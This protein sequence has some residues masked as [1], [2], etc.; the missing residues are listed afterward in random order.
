[1]TPNMREELIRVN[2]DLSHEE[3]ALREA[4]L[5]ASAYATA[6][7]AIANSDLEDEANY[8]HLHGIRA[9]CATLETETRVMRNRVHNIEM[10]TERRDRMMQEE[11]GEQS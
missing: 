11:A 5:T 2:S 1:M 6:I 4:A 10:L 7:E 8:R 3:K 9:L